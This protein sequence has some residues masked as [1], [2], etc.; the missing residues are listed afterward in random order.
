MSYMRRTSHSEMLLTLV[1]YFITPR[2]IHNPLYIDN[3]GVF[4]VTVEP[5]LID[6]EKGK[7]NQ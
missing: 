7:Y 2:A 6:I 5:D 4:C 3:S 1:N